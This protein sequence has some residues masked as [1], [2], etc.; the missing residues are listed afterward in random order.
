[1]GIFEAAVTRLD[2][3]AGFIPR[4][5]TDVLRIPLRKLLECPY[6]MAV[7]SLQNME[8]R[9]KEEEKQKVQCL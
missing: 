3:A 8:P 6:E 7:N 2:G 4:I 9:R 1:M 5:L